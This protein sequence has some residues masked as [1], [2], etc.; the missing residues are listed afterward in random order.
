M[1]KFLRGFL[2]M[3]RF[4]RDWDNGEAFLELKMY[5]FRISG[6]SGFFVLELWGGIVGFGNVGRFV[7][8]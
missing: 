2:G 6:I 8:F 3:G 5:A 1:G 7:V 4:C